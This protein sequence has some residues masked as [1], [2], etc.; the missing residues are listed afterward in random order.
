MVSI[1]LVEVLNHPIIIPGEP[2]GSQSTITATSTTTTTT[3]SQT[4]TA[5]PYVVFTKPGTPLS[6]FQNLIASLDADTE[7]SQQIT[8]PTL[9]WQLYVTP[10]T[11]AQV[12]IAE[13][14]PVVHMAHED[15]FFKNYDDDGESV[16]VTSR[17][18]KKGMHHTSEKAQVFTYHGE[19]NETQLAAKIIKRAPVQQVP[20]PDHLKL[21]S[22]PSTGIDGDYAYDDT[23]TG[24]GITIYDID[25]G[26][27]INHEVSLLF[28]LKYPSSR[29]C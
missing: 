29:N 2:T 21:L 9:D 15:I 18:K 11:P 14:N 10:L 24:A 8:Y 28:F 13:A 3:S 1:I 22:R 26:I 19:Q 17:L 12:K 23:A 27:N 6:S 25:Q 16:L 20:S 7:Q 4:A 5:T